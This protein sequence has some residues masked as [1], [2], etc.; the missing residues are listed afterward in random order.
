MIFRVGGR[1]TIMC[2][3]DGEKR[4][5]EQNQTPSHLAQVEKT[6]LTHI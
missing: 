6:P 2:A 1:V 3:T 5:G 4:A